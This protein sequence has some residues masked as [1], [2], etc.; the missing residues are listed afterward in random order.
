MGVEII[1]RWEA[2][3]FPSFAY[4]FLP[5]GI[6]YYSMADAKKEF[7]YK[8]DADCVNI[9]YPGDIAALNF[10]YQINEDILSIEDSFGK[11]VKYKKM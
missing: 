5:D 10:K 4:N 3:G 8:I 9:Y 7:T 11:I 2:V 1:G 6:G